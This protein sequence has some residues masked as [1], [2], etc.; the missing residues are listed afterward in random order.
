MPEINEHSRAAGLAEAKHTDRKDTAES[1]RSTAD[2]QRRSPL[3]LSSG[4]ISLVV[5]LLLFAVAGVVTLISAGLNLI[6]GV[7]GFA[8]NYG[9]VFMLWIWAKGKGL[10]PPTFTSSTKFTIK[11]PKA[12]ATYKKWESE[13]NQAGVTGGGAGGVGGA[14]ESVESAIPGNDIIF[15]ALGGISP[16]VYIFGLWMNNG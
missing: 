16:A 8:L 5:W 7:L 12:L 14:L 15:I 13:M 11:D 4:G 1:A 10:K 3:T 6:S 9:A 2:K